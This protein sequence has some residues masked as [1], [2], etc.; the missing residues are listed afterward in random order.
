MGLGSELGS[1]EPMSQPQLRVKLVVAAGVV[2]ASLLAATF[3]GCQSSPTS[4]AQSGPYG[5]YN[6]GQY[7][8]GQYANNQSGNNPYA[9]NPL[10]GNQFA[11]GATGQQAPPFGSPPQMAA[12]TGAG[13]G[14]PPQNQQAFL[15]ETQRLGTQQNLTAQDVVAMSRSGIPDQ[16][17]A[18]A[19]QQRGAALRTTPGVP[20]YL[21]QYGVNPAVLGQ[22][23]AGSYPGAYAPQV[24][25]N[26]PQAAYGS[27]ANPSRP[28]F[29]TAPTSGVTSATYPTAQADAGQLQSA[30]Y[31]SS[32][33]TPALDTSAS[34]TNGTMNAPAWRAMPH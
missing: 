30:A 21:S 14:L 4:Q 19:I 9:G 12:T 28:P 6:G 16:Q 10:G 5:Q 20:Q 23:Q 1:S 22:S 34:P 3:V 32:L 33:A 17:I 18:L 27:N 13:N 8:G 29:N 24:A 7:N 31:E 11:G 15:N 25:L 26:D 2:G